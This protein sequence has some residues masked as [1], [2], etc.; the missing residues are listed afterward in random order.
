MSHIERRLESMFCPEY[1][2]PVEDASIR[3]V[4]WS[5]MG[6]STVPSVCGLPVCS[7]LCT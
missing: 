5:H 7:N 6:Q 3:H 2:S 4:G 1:E